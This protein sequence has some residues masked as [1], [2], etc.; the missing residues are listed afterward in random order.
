MLRLFALAG[1]MTVTGAAL[2]PQ[3]AQAQNAMLYTVTY[4]EV[5]PVL[6]KIGAVALHAYRDAARKDATSLDV[7]QRMDRPNQFVIL[8]AWADQKAFE[9]HTAGAAAKKLNEKLATMLASPTDTRQHNGLSVAPA[10]AA[11]FTRP[12]EDA[13]ETTVLISSIWC[14]H[15]T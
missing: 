15:A 1:L 4:I 10:K 2:G 6:A 3:P 13:A 5:G 9:T 12:G 7:F 14:A 11:Q 8:G